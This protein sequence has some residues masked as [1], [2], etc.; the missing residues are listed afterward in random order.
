MSKFQP[1]ILYVFG[2]LGTALCMALIGTFV[3]LEKSYPD[4]QHLDKFSWIPLVSVIGVV[5]IRS[6]CILPVLMSL[7]SEV[8]P[9]EIRT[10]SNGLVQAF[11]M[12][13]GAICLSLFPIQ[14]KFMGLHSL[15]FFYGAL[16]IISCIWGLNKI[17]DNRGKSLVE[18]E[19]MYE[20]DGDMTKL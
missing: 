12:I 11:E 10:Q 16:G 6:V 15:L 18:V 17:P 19:E 9:T 3:F 20:N 13:S 5:I 8:F 7:S 2:T 4:L 1:R 14:E